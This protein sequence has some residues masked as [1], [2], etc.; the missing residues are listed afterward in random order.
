[1]AEPARIYRPIFIGAA[2]SMGLA[3]LLMWSMEERPLKSREL[4]VAKAAEEAA[5]TLSNTDFH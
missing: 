1:V 4:P 3:F 2:V 5:D